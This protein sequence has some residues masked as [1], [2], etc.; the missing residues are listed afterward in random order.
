M[1][2]G[3]AKPVPVN[4]HRLRS[5]RRDMI[6]VAAAGPA[7]NLIM[8]TAAASLFHVLPIFSGMMR[9]WIQLNLEAAVLINLLLCVFNML[10]MP[11]LDGGRIAV[12]ILPRTLAAPLARLE[13]VGVLII[14][15]GVFLL[16]WLG[17]K[18][19]WDLDVF[20]WLVGQPAIVLQK[21]VYSLTGV[22]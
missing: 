13:R 18:V 6:L 21:T 14:L 7:T 8:A 4:F 22:L 5:P 15:G 19:G 16:P 9:G 11:P 12:G 1:M 10:P 20:W 2:F 17:S 3:F